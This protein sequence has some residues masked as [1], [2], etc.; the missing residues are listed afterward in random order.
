M[1]QVME[2]LYAPFPPELIKFRAGATSRDK[3]TALGLAYV[4]PRA[5]MQRL[6]EVVDYWSDDYEIKVLD[7]RIFVTCRLTLNGNVTRCD[8]GE[9]PLLTR[10]GEINDNALTTAAAQAF[11]RACAKF[12]LGAF[13]YD[14]PKVFAEYDGYKFTPQ[15][16]SKLRRMLTNQGAPTP[17]PVKQEAPAPRVNEDT[18]EVFPFDIRKMGEPQPGEVGYSAVNW[19][20][21]DVKLSGDIGPSKKYPDRVFKSHIHAMN[22][23]NKLKEERS[24]KSAQEMAVLWMEEVDRRRIEIEEGGVPS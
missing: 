17:H 3:K 16:L 1:N 4:D 22:A 13:L 14:F 10:K 12:G 11:K 15:G 23:Y 2:T 8:V 20:W 5:Y 18:G 6:D 7:D 24:P 21:E 19:A 9:E